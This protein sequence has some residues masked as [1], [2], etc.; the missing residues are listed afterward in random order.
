MSEDKQWAS[1]YL[2]DPLNAPQPSEETGPGSSF[3]TPPDQKA[4]PSNR[5]S[6]LQ[7]S[8]SGPPRGLGVD[9]KNKYPTPPTSASPRMEQFPTMSAHHSPTGSRSG[10]LSPTSPIGESS[11][12]RRGSSLTARFP[13]DQSHR[14]LDI[15]KHDAKLAQRAPH[16]RK[17]HLPGPDT[18]DG[19][20]TT[21]FAYHHEGPYDA[22][23]LAR[24]TSGPISPVA[25]VRGTNEKALRATP[26][27]KIQDSLQRH[28]PL[29]GVAVVPPGMTDLSGQR[30]DY[31]EGADL[32]IEAGYKRWPGVT[33]LPEDLKGKGE[34]SF[35]IEKA[36]K[37]H[38]PNSHRRVVS[39]GDGA[40][41]MAS[42][43]RPA[44]AGGHGAEQH[45]PKMKTYNQ[46]ES[47]LHPNQGHSHS[48]SLSGGLKRRFN[49][50]RHRKAS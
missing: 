2:L 14:P 28:R 31:E 17:K 11:G 8:S 26:R 21:G 41:E 10:Q 34:P 13:G 46:W 47:D 43:A 30:M 27:E 35:S 40:Y 36:L 3:I 45:G 37:E 25:A 18:I 15:L 32:M 49:S 9:V 23:L 12:R 42:R 16:L 24:N 39:E 20:D 1:K 4:R 19:L 29:D 7:R 6:Y 33:Y 22:T 50:L 38:Q 5:P 44:S 48:H